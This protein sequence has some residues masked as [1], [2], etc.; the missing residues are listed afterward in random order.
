MKIGILNFLKGFA[1][2]IVI[3]SSACQTTGHDPV[4]RDFQIYIQAIRDKEALMQGQK[5]GRK[6]SYSNAYNYWYSERNIYTSDEI[7]R[8][9]ENSTDV[10]FQRII[11]R[12]RNEK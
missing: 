7:K 3:A 6:F 4:V 5:E 1:L 9:L 12:L 10:D 8:S 2:L 11:Q